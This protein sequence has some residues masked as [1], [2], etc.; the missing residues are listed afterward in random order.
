MSEI[1]YTLVSDG[2]SDASLLPILNWLLIQNGV[3]EAIQA[4]WADLR[5]LPRSPATLAE[6]IA[7]SLEYYPCELLFIHRDAER[8]APVVREREIHVALRQLSDMMSAIEPVCVIPV[9]MTE[10]W[11]LID[12]NAI[13]QAAGNR[14]SR[15]PLHLPSLH[16][17][18]LLPDPKQVLYALLKEA[19]GLSGQ[20]LRRFRV[21]FHASRVSGF[22]DDFTALR[23][24]S[25]FVSLER[26]I[27]TFIE[28][29]DGE[30]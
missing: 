3:T 18:E 22:I 7:R 23:H 17:L 5:G 8:D 14:S 24:L 1:R 26:S 19:S 10:A 11:L 20:R 28:N 21:A 30:R 6:K 15:Q 4:T 16:E 13:R 27:K 12:E 25:A 2:S 29:S 9:R